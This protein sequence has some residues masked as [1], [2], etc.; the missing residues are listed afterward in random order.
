MLHVIGD[1]RFKQ[2]QGKF[3]GVLKKVDYK[4]RI[5]FVHNTRCARRCARGTDSSSY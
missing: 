3:K 5:T 4:I 1:L 2:S